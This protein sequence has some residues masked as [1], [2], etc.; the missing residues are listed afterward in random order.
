MPKC[1]CVAN[2]SHA[3]NRAL[4][5]IIL[6]RRVSRSHRT[7][8]QTG[9]L[10]C[11]IHILHSVQMQRIRGEI[12]HIIHSFVN[13]YNIM[14]AFCTCLVP[15]THTHTHTD[16]AL[17]LLS[18][19]ISSFLLPLAV[20]DSHLAAPGVVAILFIHLFVFCFFVI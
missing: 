5:K 13:N 17:L 10:K 16:Y 18:M 15:N 4:Q 1:G 19:L 8:W 7:L 2:C 12:L 6:S 14:Y 3:P 20:V 11:F 9:T